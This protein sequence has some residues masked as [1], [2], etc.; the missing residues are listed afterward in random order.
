MSTNRSATARSKL[1]STGYL[2]TTFDPS[3]S[4]SMG[5][6]FEFIEHNGSWTRNEDPQ[7]VQAFDAALVFLK[8]HTK[9]K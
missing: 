8:E 5:H 1:M 3:W 4:G 2:E 9:P 7:V 6:G